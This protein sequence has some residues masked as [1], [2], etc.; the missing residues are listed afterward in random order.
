[1]VQKKFSFFHFPDVKIGKIVRLDVLK[2]GVVLVLRASDRPEAGRLTG[3]Q[4]PGAEMVR[5]GVEG[6]RNSMGDKGICLDFKERNEK[7]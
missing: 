5:A 3:N 6:S 2:I 1:M 4:G 7:D